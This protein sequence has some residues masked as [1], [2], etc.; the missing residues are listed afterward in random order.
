MKKSNFGC[1][2]RSFSRRDSD[3]SESMPFKA[4][5]RTILKPPKVEPGQA[6]G[7]IAPAGPVKEEEIRSDF[8]K[9]FKLLSLRE[10]RF[11]TA[12]G[13]GAGALAL[14]VLLKRNSPP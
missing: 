12:G 1:V 14:F 4:M 6:V 8:A 5:A 7:V 3:I 10:F 13:D 9:G 11:D 2:W